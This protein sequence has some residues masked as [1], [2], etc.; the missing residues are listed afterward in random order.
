MLIA[1]GFLYQTYDG[2]FVVRGRF[3]AKEEALVIF[4]LS[5]VVLAAVT[6]MVESVWTGVV[7]AVST[8]TVVGFTLLSEMLL[9]NELSKWNFT[10]QKS[11]TNYIIGAVFMVLPHL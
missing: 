6:P 10:D 5:F 8:T 7:E 11:V 9:V 2:A 4:L 3:R 1:G